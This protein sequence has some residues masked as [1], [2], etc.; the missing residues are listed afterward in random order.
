[1]SVRSSLLYRRVIDFRPGVNIRAT[2][3]QEPN[4]F[5]MTIPGGG[6]Y[7]WPPARS[8]PVHVCA[9]PKQY[10]HFREVAVPRRSRKLSRPLFTNVIIAHEQEE[11]E[12]CCK[13]GGSY[14]QLSFHSK[15]FFQTRMPNA[16]LQRRRAATADSS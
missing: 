1:M 4:D 9:Q 2:V 8:I 16:A 14:S 3:K 6:N 5:G 11:D 15:E 12:K 10:P 7:C 13:G